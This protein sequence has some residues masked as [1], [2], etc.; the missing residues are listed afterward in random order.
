[1]ARSWF[2]TPETVQVPLPDGQWIELKKRLTAGEARKAMASLVS[3]VRTDGRM[4]PNLEMVGKAEVIAYLVDW[5]LVDAH[6][7][8][9]SIDT[10]AKKLAAIDNLDEDHYTVI[11]DHVSKHIA[12]MTAER[13]AE[14]NV[15]ATP[16][17]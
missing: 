8:R 10:P 1:M 15:P 5:S 2:V 6:G 3:E 4:T 13:E 12:E 16:N 9:V 11:A 14:K 17:G 7:R